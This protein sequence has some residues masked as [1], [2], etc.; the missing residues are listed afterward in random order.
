LLSI[1]PEVL[2]NPTEF[3][4]KTQLLSLA[5]EE[6]ETDEL[7]ELLIEIELER[8]LDRELERELDRLELEIELD[9][10]LELIELETE[11]PLH[12]LPLTV[13]APAAPLA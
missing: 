2:Q 9:L 6:E 7:L 10:E 5:V 12:K 1:T 8:E 11:V 4:S 13:G 3:S